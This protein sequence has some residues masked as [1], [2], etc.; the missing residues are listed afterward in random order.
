M[1]IPDT[2]EMPKADVDEIADLS[3]NSMVG[4]SALKTM[5]L[6]EKIAHQEVVTM[7]DC[8]LLIIYFDKID[9]EIGDIFA[10]HYSLWVLMDTGMAVKGEDIYREVSLTLQNIERV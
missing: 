6:K 2:G 5:K 10:S 4:L 1:R 7:I 3:V 8:G 9:S